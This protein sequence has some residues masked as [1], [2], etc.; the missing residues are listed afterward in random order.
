MYGKCVNQALES[1]LDWI[2]Y[3]LLHVLK[4]KLSLAS[5]LLQARSCRDENMEEKGSHGRLLL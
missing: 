5:L 4:K 2:E 1:G 3:A